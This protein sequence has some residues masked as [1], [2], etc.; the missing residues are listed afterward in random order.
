MLESEGFG[1]SRSK[2]T[3]DVVFVSAFDGI[4]ICGGG[5]TDAT[6]LSTT[7]VISGVTLGIIA[8]VASLELES[9]TVSFVT[10]A[11]V[12]IVA[13]APPTGGSNES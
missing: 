12:V 6:V 5:G 8:T 2:V 7:E 10:V 4:G 3:I 1:G 9:L 13:A 11:S